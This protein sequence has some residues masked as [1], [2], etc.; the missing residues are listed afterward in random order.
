[1]V[2]ILNS[3]IDT[4]KEIGK[5]LN[6]AEKNFLNKIH[7][8]EESKNIVLKCR[9]GNKIHL[10]VTPREQYWSDGAIMEL[11]G[12]F[13]CLNQFNQSNKQEIGEL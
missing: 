6:K 1:M 8:N 10:Y 3:K 7:N 13:K 5:I 11:S 4:M 12:C 9:H 2:G